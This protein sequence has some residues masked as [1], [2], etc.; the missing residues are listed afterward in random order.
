MRD[1]GQSGD[2]TL[3]KIFGGLRKIFGA[4]ETGAPPVPPRASRSADHDPFRDNY[5][6]QPASGPHRGATA[7]GA[8]V[9]AGQPMHGQM[10]PPLPS[11]GASDDE[12]HTAMLAA[13]GTLIN[14]WVD[15]NL[16]KIIEQRLQTLAQDLIN[17]SVAIALGQQLGPAVSR[18]LAAVEERIAASMTPQI[19]TAL[20][21]QLG[22]AVSREVAAVEERTGAALI[23]QVATAVGQQLG[24][25]VNR[26]AVAL[27]DR[28]STALSQQVGTAIAQQLE[29]AVNREVAAAEERMTAAVYR[30][31][32]SEIS[33]LFRPFADN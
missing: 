4:E 23:Q 33:S 9:V 13:V 5:F 14:R 7:P 30:R 20:G 24:P 21:L 18:Q 17:Q 27:K 26:E 6:G 25:A 29:P 3:E 28:L 15:Q 31:V 11:S 8:S 12:L 22:P 10:P 32:K 19:A 2:P 16:G 1:N